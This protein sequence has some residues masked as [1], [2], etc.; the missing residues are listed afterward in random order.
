MRYA[1]KICVIRLAFDDD[2]RR[3][4]EHAFE[5]ITKKVELKPVKVVDILHSR[6]IDAFAFLCNDIVARDVCPGQKQ[7]GMGGHVHPF[8]VREV[9]LPFVLIFMLKLSNDRELMGKYVNSK[10]FN[11]IAWA[12]TAI[13]I[14]LTVLL[15]I[16]T[17]FPS[18]PRLIGM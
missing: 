8:K 5:G 1:V 9:L 16:V 18:L 11:G 3:R 17:V 6:Q 15:V 7:M 12:T 2:D 4:E 14:V 10:A 13:M